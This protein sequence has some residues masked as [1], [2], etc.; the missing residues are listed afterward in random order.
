[1]NRSHTPKHGHELST[2]PGHT[3]LKRH[4]GLEPRTQPVASDSAPK[5]LLRGSPL[6]N[7]PKKYLSVCVTQGVCLSD[8]LCHLL[9]CQKQLILSS[10]IQPDYVFIPFALVIHQCGSSLHKPCGSDK[11]CLSVCVATCGSTA[12]PQL[13]LLF[14]HVCTLP[15]EPQRG[16]VSASRRAIPNEHQKKRR[17]EER[18]VVTFFKA[19][20]PHF[21]QAHCDVPKPLSPGGMYWEHPIHVSWVPGEC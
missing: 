7:S 20:P 6:P 1:M 17:P 12:L 4:W 16:A 19:I 13:F 9:M 18:G 11:S 15:R 14:F 8:R 2:N 10:E 5:Q 3:V 21:H